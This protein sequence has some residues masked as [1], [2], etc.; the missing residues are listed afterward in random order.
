MPDLRPQPC[1]ST[2]H[3]YNHPYVHEY[4]CDM[5]E[6][7][8]YPLPPP[9]RTRHPERRSRTYQEQHLSHHIFAVREHFA[10][11]PPSGGKAAEF[12]GVDDAKEFD[13]NFS[14]GRE[15]KKRKTWRTRKFRV[16]KKNAKKTEVKK[17]VPPVE[18]VQTCPPSDSTSEFPLMSHLC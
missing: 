12:F 7:I 10:Y 16:I 14:A 17:T 18:R 3:L 6:H 5:R 1:S 9:A 8:T 2:I 13:H 4:Q 11:K 15:K